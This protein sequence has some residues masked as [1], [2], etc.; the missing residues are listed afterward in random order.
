MINEH[1]E[2]QIEIKEL[3]DEGTFE[4]YASVFG[5]VDLGGDIVVKGAFKASLSAARK[6]KRMPKFLLHH[7][8][9]NVVGVFEQMNEDDRGLFVKGR[10]NLEKQLGR[11]ALSD[12][13]MGALDGL[14]I[15]YVARK[16]VRDDKTGI[17]T[18]K[19]ADILEASLV[20]FPMNEDARV[21]AVK[22]I[23]AQIKTIRDFENHLRDVGFSANAAKAIAV[24]GFKAASDDLRDGAG[25]ATTRALNELVRTLQL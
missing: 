18:I 23:A 10:F 3:T 17:R 5:N 21:S 9:R 6:A 24:G 19:E 12:V 13:K 4:G 7:D 8:T 15:G 14:S 11:E 25:D 2:S 16:V 1:L 22:S 20:T